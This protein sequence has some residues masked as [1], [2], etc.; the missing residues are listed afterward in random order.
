MIIS[1]TPVF[2]S[3]FILY[4]WKPKPKQWHTEKHNVDTSLC[5]SLVS[6][7]ALRQNIIVEDV[8]HFAISGHLVRLQPKANPALLQQLHSQLWLKG[9]NWC[10]GWRRWES[11]CK[12]PALADLKTAAMA[13]THWE[14]CGC[15]WS[16][17]A[18]LALRGDRRERSPSVLPPAVS[19]RLP[20]F[21]TYLPL[22]GC[23]WTKHH[24]CGWH[25]MR[26]CQC[27]PLPKCWKQLW[28]C[29]G[30]TLWEQ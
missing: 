19:D 15:G 7:L 9:N 13:N 20:G 26:R 27:P 24:Q 12:E 6:D 11:Q 25:G 18:S 10:D 2:L 16:P 8:F 30:N 29:R 3:K 22:R 5:V 21:V 28:T 1:I 14:I 23:S 17:A 4:F